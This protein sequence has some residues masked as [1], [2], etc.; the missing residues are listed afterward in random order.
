MEEDAEVA[1]EEDAVHEARRDR[2]GGGAV[3]APC[4][5]SSGIVTKADGRP[6]RVDA[7]K[8]GDEIVATTDEGKLT[9]DTVSLLSIAKPEKTGQF[10]LV[11]TASNAT[12][13]LTP[14]VRHH[15]CSNAVHLPNV[16]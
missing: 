16:S 4:F 5:P 3:A 10:L 14:E 6:I 7:L 12:L 8:E 1:V 11:T 15:R 13:T 9:T 2:R